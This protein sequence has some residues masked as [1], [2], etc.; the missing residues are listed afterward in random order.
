MQKTLIYQPKS[1]GQKLGQVLFFKSVN[2]GLALLPLSFAVREVSGASS[3]NTC[4]LL[5]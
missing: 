3:Q 1:M 4:P 5:C 2:R